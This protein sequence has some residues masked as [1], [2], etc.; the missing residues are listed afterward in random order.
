MGVSVTTTATDITVSV[1]DQTIS[2]S[3]GGGIGP[4]GPA[5]TAAAGVSTLN[6]LTGTLQIASAGGVTVSG[7][8]ITIGSVTSWNDLTGKP[9][10]VY[11]VAGRTG[12][13]TLTTTD[14]G[15]YQAPPVTSVAGRTGAVT[16]S[17]G[18]IGGYVAPAVSSVAGRTGAVTL[19]T[20]DITGYSAPPVTSVAGRTGVVVLTSADISNF[21]TAASAAAPVQSVAGRT[22]AVTISTADVSGYTSP[23]VTSVAGRTGAVTL[24]TSDIGG[25]VAP[26]VSSVAGRTGAVTLTSADL[27]DFA[28]A[29]AKYGPVTSVAGRTGAVTLTTSDIGG[30]TSPAVTSVAGRTGAVTLTSSDLSDF[31]TAA[32][33]YGPVTAVAGRTGAVTLTTADVSGNLVATVNGISGTPSIVAGANVTVTTA[34]SSI[35][36]AAASGSVTFATAAEA[37]DWNSTTVAMN[38]ARMLDSFLGW[39]MIMPT[40][41]ANTNGGT[42]STN[43]MTAFIDCPSA[44]AGALAA[45]YTITNGNA[46]NLLS[47][48]NRAPDWTKRRYFS[49]RI[50][51]EATAA[52][53]GYGRF[54]YGFYTAASAG[55]QPN[56]RAVGFELRGTAPRL[57]V[58]AHNGTSLTQTDSGWDVTGGSDNQNEYLV[59]SSGGTVN[60]YVDGTLRGTSSGGPTTNSTDSN[61]GINYQASNGGNSAR[62]CFYVTHA[63]FTI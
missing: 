25:Y 22:G 35:T 62:T 31:A 48:Q 42:T 2:A 59:E 52:S 46:T 28:T 18:D 7:T 32:A 34:A 33:K 24:T 49:V 4:Q 15:G 20:S 38:P 56:Q 23:P 19:S 3:V 5:S 51:R 43:P 40:Q 21:S 12:T 39:A 36:I 58:I 37:T 26:S 55:A 63:R 50:R 1:N 8:T 60:V 29:A 9:N 6:G 53:A 45:L 14:I 44:S 16:L 47:A 30:Y 57:W 10:L 11:S 17:T 54:Y 27:S 61:S 41:S 13:V